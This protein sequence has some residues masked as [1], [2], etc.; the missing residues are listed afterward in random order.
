MIENHCS[1]HP[2]HS[3]S[4]SKTIIAGSDK[5]GSPLTALPMDFFPQFSCHPR[6]I[7]SQSRPDPDQALKSH[8][9]GL[10]FFFYYYLEPFHLD[11]HFSREILCGGSHHLALRRSAPGRTAVSSIGSFPACRA[12]TTL[13]L[14]AKPEAIP[15]ARTTAANLIYNPILFGRGAL[16][17]TWSKPIVH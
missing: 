2:D 7:L 17:R 10:C 11:S 6:S 16:S 9:I 4:L 14:A 12:K 8:W 1:V 5:P 13:T 3:P 15:I